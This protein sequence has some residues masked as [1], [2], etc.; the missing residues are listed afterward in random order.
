VEAAAPEASDGELVAEALA[1]R[2]T[3]YRRLLQ[4]HR[5][6]V[7]RLLRSLTGD[8]DAAVDI[9]QEAF[10]AGFA[11]IDR[12]D[13]AR[14]FRAWIS[15]IAVNKARDWARRRK[16]RGFFNR[17]VGIVEAISVADASVLQD[18]VV[19]DR[20]DLA[21]VM[22]AIAILPHNLREVLALRTIEDKSEAETAALLG[23][24]D[25]AVET[26]LYRAR[27]RLNEILD[28]V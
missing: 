9:T 20:A 21:R 2:E 15:R 13:P 18:D 5:D 10:I 24:S 19:A 27:K 3:G 1:G 28:G 6:P 8:A 12:Y 4:R 11:A 17:A 14:P 25:K 26:R 23:I 16:V 22:Q 7:Y